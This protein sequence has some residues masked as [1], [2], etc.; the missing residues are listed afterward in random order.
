VL[1]SIL[2]FPSFDCDSVASTSSDNA[3]LSDE[4]PALRPGV[5]PS[6]KAILGIPFRRLTR[7]F[8]G[9]ST[10]QLLLS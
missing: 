6:P 2:G 3:H 1:A 10:I 8:Q 7:L 5:V 4:V 9:A